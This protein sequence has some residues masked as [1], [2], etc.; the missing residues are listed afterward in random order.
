MKTDVLVIGS[1]LAGSTAALMAA[2][3]GAEVMLITREED[4]H[5]SNTSYAQGGIVY[6][7]DGDSID[8]RVEDVLEAGAGSCRR[9]A[10]ELLSREG[11]KRV[12]SILIDDFGV[13]FDR[14]GVGNL[15]LTEEG[16]HSMPRIVHVEDLTGRSIEE[17]CIR[18][19]KKEPRI[20]LINKA[21]AVDLLTLS[22]HSKNPS[23]IYAPPTCIGAYVLFQET[24]EI[25]PILAR[26]TVLASGGVGRLFL[27]TSN[28]SGARG[29]GIAMA[30]RAGRDWP[31]W[32]MCSFIRRRCT[33]PLPNGF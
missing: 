5:I 14:N 26:E 27:H 23:D 16:A 32:N 15:D 22:H 20:R 6:E 8:L 18:T 2:R 33:T 4:P 7:G 21:T 13:P 28:P 24:G 29:D 3:A 19:L 10:V 25:V 11:P 17:C 30:Y 12:K 1:G 31:V 9:E